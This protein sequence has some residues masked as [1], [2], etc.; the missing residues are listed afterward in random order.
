MQLMS[1]TNEQIYIDTLPE[2]KNVP[3]DQAEIP[4]FSD[5]Q[6]ADV[7]EPSDRN[8]VHLP[9]TSISNLQDLNNTI[10]NLDRSVNS[11]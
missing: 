11:N 7:P 5:T 1:V 10:T 4:N 9:D 6:H 2:L 3:Y 8:N